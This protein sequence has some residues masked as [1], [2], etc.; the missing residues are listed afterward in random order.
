MTPSIPVALID[1]LRAGQ[2][3]MFV[4]AGA[5]VAAGLPTWSGL[6]DQLAG[7]LAVAYGKP[8]PGPVGD[9]LSIPQ[10]YENR[11]G[12]KRLTEAI[13]SAIPRRPRSRSKVHEVIADLPCD[14]FYTTNFDTLLE[15]ALDRVRHNHDVISTENDA[16]DYSRRDHS[17]VR[18]I[19][20]TIETA[21]SLV[22]TREDFLKYESS[23][24][25]ISERLRIDLAASTFLFIGYSL[26]DPDFSSLYDRVFRMFSPMERRHYITTFDATPYQ[27]DDLRRRGLEV[28]DLD[29]WHS[30]K[31]SDGLYRFLCALCGSTS[32]SMHLR[33]IFAGIRRDDGPIPIVIPSYTHPE[34]RYDFVPRMDLAVATALDDALSR[35]RIDARILTDAE[36]LRTRETLLQD[37]VILVGSPKGNRMTALVLEKSG[38]SSSSLASLVQFDQDD[39]AR[40]LR[41]GQS[42][43]R[44]FSSS[45]PLRAAGGA[46]G[47]EYAVT[48]RFRN[49]LQPEFRVW[50]MAGLWGL[51]TQAL[52]QFIQSGGYRDLEWDSLSD[53]ASVVQVD[54]VIQGSAV[55][56]QRPFGLSVVDTVCRQ[57]G[58]G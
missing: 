40:S 48:A 33:R 47:R 20:G 52:A 23:H 5:S 15:Q 18:K 24:P 32:D 16:R 11:F 2:A 46:G 44:K 19:H 37:D 4:G 55:E 30:P 9:L 27:V 13:R 58:D 6:V 57:G 29:Q 12:R 56:G 43:G 22:I 35:L 7:E 14:L 50:L 8:P 10:Y 28:I 54:Y 42:P 34:E 49:P 3:A 1:D 21:S 36:A 26:D 41:I 51:G 25:H 17:Q 45:D 38:A 39:H 53:A 31:G